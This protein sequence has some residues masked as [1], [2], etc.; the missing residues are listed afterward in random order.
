[1][2][3]NKEYDKN[4]SEAICLWYKEVDMYIKK[5]SVSQKKRV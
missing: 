5:G 4:R 3:E 2:W 1:M